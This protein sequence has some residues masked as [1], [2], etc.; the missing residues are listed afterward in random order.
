MTDEKDTRCS[1]CGKS[2]DEVGKLIAG[3]SGYICGD[4][5]DLC[6]TL[7]HEEIEAEEEESADKIEEKL[8]TPHEIRAHLDDYVIGQDYAKKVL[9]VALYNH[10]KRLR[11]G[12]KTDEVELSKSNVLLIGPTGSGKTLLAQTLAR[13][14][15]VPFAMA[16]A[17]TLTEAGYVGEDVENIIQK[18]LQNCDYDTEKAEQG[19]IYIDEIDKITRKSANPSITRDVSGEGVQQALLKM[20]EGTI[21]AVPPQGG[22][23]HPQQ[24]MVRVDTSKILFIC[25]GAF[26]GLDKII[27]K[28]VHVGSGIGF[29]AE[30]KGER[31]EL[32]LTDLFKQIETEDLIK[33]G[34]IPEFIGRLPVI[35]PLSELDENA[36]I[37]ILTEPKNALT[38]QYQAL[39]GLEEVELEFTPA[40]LKAMAKKALARKTGARGL[41]SIV[42][43]VLLDTMYDL[44]SQE[45]LAKVIVDED[46]IEKGEKP[47]LIFK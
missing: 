31:D 24:E 20:I 47:K 15:N 1:F 42:E 33:F 10:Y 46:V 39:F 3:T 28:R 41:R 26:A 38:K 18:L 6:H 23:K 35:A 5:I 37:S 43:G 7:L 17:T 16:D 44:P 29:N 11:S 19:I 12:H 27:E 4:C 30:V 9:A 32:T 2:Q 8:P 45:N 34:M 40:S 21:A 22:R 14:L 25:G 36:L 13:M